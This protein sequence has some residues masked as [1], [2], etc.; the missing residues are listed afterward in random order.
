MEQEL[1]NTIRIIQCKQIL[2]AQS[3][4]YAHILK[5][6][7]IVKASTLSDGINWFILSSTHHKF[8]SLYISG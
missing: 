6:W 1:V 4:P 2:L 3:M 7:S 8:S 5:W